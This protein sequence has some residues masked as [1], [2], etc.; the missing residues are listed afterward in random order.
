MAAESNLIKAADMKKIR[1]V[2]F[3]EQFTHE[4]LDKLRGD[5]VE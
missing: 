2:D 4:S 5:I 1:E 3:V